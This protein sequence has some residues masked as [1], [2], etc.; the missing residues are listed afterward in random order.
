M[1]LKPTIIGLSAALTIAYSLSPSRNLTKHCSE[2][3]ENK[4]QQDKIICFID[5]Y[6]AKITTAAKENNVPPELLAAVV[7]QENDYRLKIQDITDTISELIGRNYTAGPGQIKIS[8]AMR[9]DN[10]TTPIVKLEIESY[11]HRL[12]DPEV[13]I[14][15]IAAELNH[16]KKEAQMENI[17]Y[18]EIDLLASA[19]RNGYTPNMKLNNH[20]YDVLI[21]LRNNNIYNALNLKM[22]KHRWQDIQNYLNKTQKE[23]VE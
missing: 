4:W 9:L 5:E 13:A 18:S 2:E 6:A 11:S 21:I 19:Y 23:R 8:T 14:S 20:G 12:N 1:N 16:I 3:A 22:D 17:R 7:Y 10:I 15:Y